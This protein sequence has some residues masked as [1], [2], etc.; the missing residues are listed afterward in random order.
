MR[1]APSKGTLNEFSCDRGAEQWNL[2]QWG[3]LPFKPT[4]EKWT[5]L[6]CRYRRGVLFWGWDKTVY[7]HWRIQSGVEG[8]FFNCVFATYTV[9]ALL[10]YSLNPKFSTEKRRKLC[11]NFIFWSGRH[12]VNPIHCK[13]LGT[14]MFPPHS[15]FYAS[16]KWAQV[17]LGDRLLQFWRDLRP[18][19]HSYVI[20]MLLISLRLQIIEINA[21]RRTLTTLWWTLLQHSR[22]AEGEITRRG[23]LETRKRKLRILRAGETASASGGHHEPA[24]QGVDHPSNDQLPQVARFLQSRRSA[25]AAR[26][27]LWF[28]V[29][30]CRR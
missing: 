14:P 6:N 30:R 20:I 12:H 3:L 1:R 23:S 16:V 9:L 25:V 18:Q 24:G 5:A 27:L 11:T 2:F 29:G 28:K 4:V 26:R 19:A 13:I 22:V 17:G 15:C 10:L 8:V 7:N 21:L